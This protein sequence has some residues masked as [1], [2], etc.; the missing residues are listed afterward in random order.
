LVLARW[1]KTF[2]QSATVVY[3]FIVP[4]FVAFGLQYHAPA[5]LYPVV[6]VNLAILLAIPVTAGALVIIVLVRFFPVA[7]VHQVV[8][9]IAMLVLTVFVLALRMSRPERLFTAITTDDLRR[10]LQTVELPA[11]ERYPGTAL[12]DLMVAYAEKRAAPVMPAK[13]GITFALA[14]AVLVVVA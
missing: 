8:A 1:F 14:F 10:V 12:A 7:H 6:L 9:T 2:A 5:L 13:I 11:I 3:I 4:M